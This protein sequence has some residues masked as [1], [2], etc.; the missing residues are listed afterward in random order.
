[1]LVVEYID[2]A[3]R[4]SDPAEDPFARASPRARRSDPRGP[5]TCSLPP[6][7]SLREPILPIQVANAARS[8]QLLSDR[9]PLPAPRLAVACLISPRFSASRRERTCC[10]WTRSIGRRAGAFVN[11]LGPGIEQPSLNLYPE[12][13]AALMLRDRRR[14]RRAEGHCGPP[15]SIRPSP[16]SVSPRIATRAISRRSASFSPA[17]SPEPGGV[18]F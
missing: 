12:A 6:F 13:L 18:S 8:L 5:S 17:I 4:S 1:V 3:L 10:A 7:S 15:P 9:R 14:R 2:G 11:H 16:S